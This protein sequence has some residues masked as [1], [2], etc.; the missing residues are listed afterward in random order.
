MNLRFDARSGWP[1][2]RLRL[3]C[4]CAG[5]AIILALALCSC[6]NGSGPTASARKDP[7]A[8]LQSTPTQTYLIPS[9][10]SAPI[11]ESPA[12]IPNVVP[13]LTVTPIP[14]A[15]A[16]PSAPTA[17]DTRTDIQSPSRTQYTLSVRMDYEQHHLAVSET[18][19]YVNR[20]REPLSDLLLVVEPNQTPGVFRLNQMSWTD[21]LP[22][23]G[24][25]LEG[26]K[27]EVPLPKPLAPGANVDL[28][29]S[30]ELGLPAQRGPFGYTMRQTNLGDWYPFAPSYRTG[31]GWLVHEP[32]V[33]GEYLV[34]DEADY[35]VDIGLANSVNG[36]QIAASGLVGTDQGQYRYRLDAAR[37]FAWSVSSEYAVVTGSVGTKTVVG[38]VFPEHLT[39]GEAALST[40]VQALALFT[41]LFGAYPHRDLSVVE[42]DFADGMEYDSLYFLGQEYY[43]AYT[44]DPRGYLTTIAAHETSHQWWY[45][46]VGNDPALEPWL[47]ESLATYSELLFY[48]T[49]YPH[50]ADWWWEFRVRRFN[51]VG[52]VDSTIYD[53]SGFRP[54]VD[55]VYLRGAFFLED[56][57]RTIG[58]EVFLAFLRDYAT[59]NAHDEVTAEDFF[60]VLAEHSPAD[61]ASLLQTY[62][63]PTVHFPLD[64]QAH[65]PP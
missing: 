6:Y 24:F 3:F 28:H 1:R 8:S 61:L 52:W 48:E 38:Y 53:H 42:A 15:V 29:L 21:S 14:P 56:L 43:A 46:L 7:S 27:L 31:Q 10:T 55:A 58:T 23:A 39:A 34:Y 41:E 19:T 18:I 13:S 25:T 57:R 47:D 11:P 49:L 51:P 62:F 44:G 2:S 65:D 37:S 63:S 36:L 5:L 50:L 60:S 54:Y 59:R 16:A 4:I 12:P 64:G 33:N 40:T 22:V 32:S 26:V 9:D 20:S 17:T 35:Q 45:G 30:F